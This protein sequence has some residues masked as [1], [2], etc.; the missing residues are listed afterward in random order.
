MP[1]EVPKPYKK[2]KF[3]TGTLSQ[4]TSFVNQNP[5]V[6]GGVWDDIQ[7]MSVNEIADLLTVYKEADE[8]KPIPTPAPLLELNIKAKKQDQWHQVTSLAELEQYRAQG[9]ALEFYS[10]VLGE[11]LPLTP[12]SQYNKPNF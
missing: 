10:T 11:R 2:L 12:H 6:A 9:C 7:P 3:P 5:A 4:Y 1:T 8:T